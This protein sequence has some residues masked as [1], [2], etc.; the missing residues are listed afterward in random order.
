LVSPNELTSEQAADGM[1]DVPQLYIASYFAGM[2]CYEFTF[3]YNNTNL[4]HKYEHG[5]SK[6]KSYKTS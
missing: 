1:V 2:V 3:I 6:I 4:N 5:N